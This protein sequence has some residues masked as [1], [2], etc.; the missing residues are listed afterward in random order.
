VSGKQTNGASTIDA[1]LEAAAK[2]YTERAAD[3]ERLRVTNHR[4]NDHDMDEELKAEAERSVQKAIEL[5]RL[6]ATEKRLSRS[7]PH[8]A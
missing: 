3:I 4:L 2:H 5:E 1:L 8:P 6:R 7:I